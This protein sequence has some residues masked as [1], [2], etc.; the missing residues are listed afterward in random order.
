MRPSR[1]L[2]ILLCHKMIPIKRKQ[3][4]K[5][6]VRKKKK[7]KNTRLHHPAYHRPLHF[8]LVIRSKKTFPARIPIMRKQRKRHL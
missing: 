1:K 8:Q 4:M 6:L 2:L 5:L 7:K 3:R